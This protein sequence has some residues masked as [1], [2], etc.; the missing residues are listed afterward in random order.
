MPVL[1]DPTRL[2]QAVANLLH[3][4]AKYTRPGGR[5]DVSLRI[6]GADATLRV[7]DTGVGIPPS[8]LQHIF[9]PFIQV[10]GSIEP[11]WNLQLGVSKPRQPRS[12]SSDWTLRW[13]RLRR[14][15]LLALPAGT[16]KIVASARIPTFSWLPASNRLRGALIGAM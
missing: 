15:Q 8:M 16:R 4:A 14:P 6:E 1:G 3:N 7:R 10:D 5:I 2:D 12:A 13:Q 9:E 11:T